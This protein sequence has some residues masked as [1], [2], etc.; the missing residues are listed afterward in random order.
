MD[1][2]QRLFIAAGLSEEG[3]GEIAR[4]VK[5]LRLRDGGLLRWVGEGNLHLTLR[6]LGERPVGEIAG[7]EEAILE[8]AG[9]FGE[10]ELRFGELG[11]FGG[12]RPRVLWLAPIAGLGEVAAL[13]ERVDAA[14]AGAGFARREGAF[15]PHVTLGR[16][17]RGDQAAAAALLPG[18]LAEAEVPEIACAVSRVELVRS[19]LGREGAR[20]SVLAS[21]QLEGG[22][23]LG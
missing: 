2:T 17:R 16:V 9:G 8:A 3:R 22:S 10:F 5:G 20:Y 1:G 6:F 19:E 14:L 15:R 18:L 21:A 7:V 23:R 12:R 4:V 11:V 13:A